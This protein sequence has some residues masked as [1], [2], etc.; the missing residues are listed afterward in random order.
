MNCGR[1]SV[2][3]AYVDVLLAHPEY[4]VFMDTID[5]IPYDSL[6]RVPRDVRLHHNGLGLGPPYPALDIYSSPSASLIHRGLQ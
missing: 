3:S 6:V 2:A 5:R 4:M 1:K